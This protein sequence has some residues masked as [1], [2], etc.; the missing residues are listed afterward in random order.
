MKQTYF[1]RHVYAEGLRQLRLMG[2]LFTAAT[3]LI[4]VSGP[5]M[6]YMASLDAIGVTVQNINYYQ[7]NPLIFLSFC[8]VAPFLTLNLFS[9]LNRRESSDFYHAIPA[10]RTCLFFSFFAAVVTWIFIFIGVTTAL[11][12]L[13]HA[14]FPQLYA[15]NY[16]SVLIICFNCFAGSLLVAASVAIAMSV[17][18]VFITNGL[19]ALLIIFLPRLLI[20]LV[21]SA[22][23]SSF[24]LITG[25]D[26]LPFLN[27]KYNVP[28]GFVLGYFSRGATD[29]VT[30]WQS[31][32]YTLVLA[33]LYTVFAWLLFKRRH[34]ESASHAAPSRRFQAF[35]R[36]LIGFAISSMV[37][38]SLWSDLRFGHIGAYEIAQLVFLYSIAIFASLVFELLYT[39]RFRGLLR[40]GATTVLLLAVAN[41]ALIGIIAGANALLV[42][43]SPEPEDIT[44][45]RIV[46][47]ES[48][49]MYGH[50]SDYFDQKTAD[51]QLDDPEVL[52]MVS[53]RLSQSLKL[54][55][56]SE[57]L[58]YNECGNN[59]S[60]VVAIK[61]GGVSH[62]RRIVLYE[63]DIQLLS[64]QLAKNREFQA[65]YMALPDNYA[66]IQD[67]TG[68]GFFLDS[69]RGAALYAALQKEVNTIGFEGWYA[70]LNS[71]RIATGTEPPIAELC[72]DVPVDSSWTS[73]RVPLYPSK[74]P[75][76]CQVYIELY[77]EQEATNRDT[78]L[79]DLAD[80][81][82]AYIS[83]ECHLYRVNGV[84]TIV[85]YW[86]EADI[87][88]DSEA[89]K[90]WAAQ[91]SV[92][93][94]IGTET[95]LCYLRCGKRVT[96]QGT[97]RVYYDTE[98]YDGYFALPTG[99]SFP[100]AD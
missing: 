21:L 4:A 89:I 30:A 44:S 74:L 1:N 31:G 10:T 78:L 16:T 65:A 55:E 17:T 27:V 8:I 24:P 29:A 98:V 99:V 3:A 63:D 59:A 69:K 12:V 38:L 13:F 96:Y 52:S 41:G 42:S 37:T 40:R 35:Y 34:S 70:L 100:A 36:F 43:Y 80:K 88:A 53:E 77:N 50:S 9:F 82:S 45:I 62:L 33:L 97:D 6:E 11:S 7:M 61:S 79:A 67:I 19:V 71:G 46:E 93:A 47:Q 87:L 5:I 85:R 20:M 91:L 95:P 58:Y 28:A 86:Q 26:F 90:A 14:L 23:E 18:G 73:F 75:Q 76:T 56:Q 72:I 81:P 68:T 2:I 66:S 60:M 51:I 25:V 22:V 15:I 94:P 92:E 39:R 32:V 64:D 57:A 49:V 54:A 84:D 83:M 48:N